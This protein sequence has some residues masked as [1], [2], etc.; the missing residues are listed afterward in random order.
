MLIGLDASR[1]AS[2]QRTGTEGYSLHLIRALLEIDQRNEYVLYFHRPPRPGLFPASPRWRARVIPFPRLWT[3]VRL[4][5]EM[6][7]APPDVLFVPAHVLPLVRPRRSVVTVH[8]LGYRHE[9]Q[10]HRLL[11]RLY[12]ELSTRYNARAASHVIADSTATK[13]DLVQLYGT[14]PDRITVIPL[15]LD[16]LFQ[17]VTDPA[18]LA[19]VRA[20]YGIPGDYLLYVGTLQPRKN[21]VRLIEAWARVIADC[22]LQIADLGRWTLVLAGKKGWLYEEI[23]ATVRRLGLEGRVLFPGYV[24]E[25]DLPALLSGATAFVWPSLYEGFGLPVLE[26]M[27][28]GTPVIAAN[29]SSLPEVVGDAGLLVDPLD[30]EALAAA[31]Q[32]LLAD[33][34]P[35]TPLRASLRAELRQRGLA[36]AK[37]FSWPRCARETLAVLERRL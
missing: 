23:F 1:A 36:R 10:A 37:L 15:G 30:S 5:L 22:R 20:R 13:R 21:L 9:P 29:V 4:S 35:S 32:R 19:D 8:D 12:L 18:R 34:D 26:A 14:D 24:P 17:P 3:H 2:A 33:A 11:D 27:A 16:E 6:L 25:E 31:M 28:C 7:T